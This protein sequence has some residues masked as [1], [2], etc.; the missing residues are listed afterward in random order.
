MPTQCILHYVASQCGA[1]REFTSRIG[2]ERTVPL[3]ASIPDAY[4][5]RL[6][7]TY[8][9]VMRG[10]SDRMEPL[11]TIRRRRGRLAPWY[12]HRMP[13]TQTRMSPTRS[14]VSPYV[15][16]Y[17]PQDRWQWVN[18]TRRRHQ[19]YRDKKEQ[20]WLAH[21]TRNGRSSSQLWHSLSTLLCR[22]RDLASATGHSADGF[23]AFFSRKIDDIRAQTAG[24]SPPPFRQRHRCRRSARALPAKY[25]GSS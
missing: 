11:H 21:L 18:A 5:D 2:R 10:I 15:G 8:D 13:L 16:L 6:F 14:P 12:R 4:V 9:A 20:Y 19:A 17:A 1:T 3:P 25:A 7:D 23:A 22:D 24:A